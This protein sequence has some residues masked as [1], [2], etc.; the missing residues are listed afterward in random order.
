MTAPASQRLRSIDALRGLAALVVSLGHALTATVAPFGEIGQAAIHGVANLAASGVPLFFVISGFCIHLSYARQRQ[1]TG[2]GSFDFVAFWRRRLWRLY[3]TYFVVLCL[4]TAGLGLL[5]WR[6]PAASTLAG[7]PEPRRNWIAADF[8]THALMLHGLHPRFD[9]GAGNPPF[10]TLAREEYL[11]L[12]Y[13]ALLFFR[14]RLRA[15]GTGIAISLGGLAVYYFLVPLAPATPEWA[16]LLRTSA[17][18]LWIQWYL[19][20]VAAESFCGLI[21]L[22]VIFRSIWAAPLWLAAASVF[23]PLEAILTGIAYFTLV[24]SC[25]QAEQRGR[26]FDGGALRFLSAT[27]L[28]SYSLYLVHFPVQTALVSVSLRFGQFQSPIMFFVRALLLTAGSYWSARLL[29]AG[30]ESRFLFSHPTPAPGGLATS[31]PVTH[32]AGVARTP[33]GSMTIGR[34]GGKA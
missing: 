22:P 25:V 13:P 16:D 12:M 1:R 8:V 10:W 15:L 3:P 9:H 28:F 21:T 17:P 11:Y 26:W 7:Y 6:V 34:S 30:V 18:Y 2:H 20:S 32:D 33:V 27:G 5:Y 23:P 4:C 14:P 19:G 29:F 31:A 24:N